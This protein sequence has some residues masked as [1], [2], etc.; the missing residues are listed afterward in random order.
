MRICLLYNPRSGRGS[1]EGVAL[2]LGQ[3]LRGV[4][5]AVLPLAATRDLT[6]G[7]LADAMRSSDLTVIAGGDG[8]V[9]HALPAL[10]ETGA[11][12][13]HF[14]LGTENLLCRQFGSD[15]DPARLLGAIGRGR[16][17]AC[18]AAACGDRLLAIMVSV[19]FDACVVERVAAARTAGVTRLDYVRHALTELAAPRTPELTVRVDGRAVVER[20]HG[21]AVIAN[22][23][24]YAA[25]LNPARDADMSDGL[26]D[27]TFLPHRSIVGLTQWLLASA[28]GLHVHLPGAVTARGT[29]VDLESD[30][31]WPHQIDGEAAGPTPELGPGRYGVGVRVL[32]G[33]LRV[34]VP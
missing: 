3:T 34:L 11:T 2:S 32:P 15:R 13:Y 31:P 4:G 28:T 23:R 26:L 17:V 30:R 14:P 21:L 33:V 25:R 8:T 20:A 18:D 10:V 12:F 19:G 6:L 5:H 24:Q 1:G 22:S 29:R 7:A 27:L 9:H 16:V